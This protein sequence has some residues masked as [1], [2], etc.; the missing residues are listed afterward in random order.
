VEVLLGDAK[1]FRISWLIALFLAARGVDRIFGLCGGHIQP[2][3]DDAARLG[4]RIIDVRDERAAVHMCQAH[5]ELTGQLGVAVVTAGPGMTNSVTGIA[6]AHCSRVPILVI[7]G[8]PPRPQRKMGALQELPQ[9]EMVRPITRYARTVCEAAHVIRELDEALACASGQGGEP[10]PAYLDFPTDLLREEL[11]AGLLELERFQAR[12]SF[13]ILPPVTALEKA[14]DLLWS[15]R[16]PLVISGRG[17]AGAGAQLARLVNA[18][19]CA[20][21]DTAESRGLLPESHPGFLPAMRSRLMREADLVLTV[22]RCLDAQLGYGSRAVFPKARFVRVG[23]SASELRANRR[24]EMELFGTVSEVLEGILEAAG[25]RPAAADRA[26]MKDLREKDR[27]RR[28]DLHRELSQ[29]AP[30]ADGRMH[31]YRLLGCLRQALGPHAIV[32]ADGGDILSF[33]RVAFNGWRYL[34]PG[35]LGCLGVGVPYGIGAALAFPSRQ[36]VV[37]TG[38]GSFGFNAMELETAKRHN[39]RVLF[40]VANNSAWNIERN[41]QLEN[42]AGRLIGVE[43]GDADYAAMARSL[44][45]HGERVERVEDLPG[46]LERAL[47]EAPALI[48]V[49][50]T[51]DAVSPDGRSG[52]PRVPDTQPLTTWDQMEKS[53][54]LLHGRPRAIGEQESGPA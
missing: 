21:L 22:G 23:I 11:P 18:L 47:G 50:V 42:Y 14:A 31:P 35:P 53:R 15:A 37:V 8:C 45:V 48:D 3:W 52:L 34:D 2:I 49:L 51:R 24:G 27:R 19:G 4:I 46:A 36:V 25:D 9:V 17:A 44:G 33:C 5:C 28:E 39:A 54:R 13:P 1:A 38:D 29:A 40:V 6:N 26:W 16:R 41:D 32:V 7:S 30:G 43:L 10:G 20:Y 12:A